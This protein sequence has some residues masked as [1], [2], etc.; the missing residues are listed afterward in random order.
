MGAFDHE[1]DRVREARLAVTNGV[2]ASSLNALRN[3]LRA[4]V[5]AIRNPWDG[6]ICTVELPTV[7]RRSS[8][9]CRRGRRSIMAP[10]R[11]TIVSI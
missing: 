1:A 5:S 4:S 7:I 2:S 10:D 8:L 9:I 3:D 11:E 6:V